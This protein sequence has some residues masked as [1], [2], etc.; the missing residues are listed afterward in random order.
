MIKYKK[1]KGVFHGIDIDP[2]FPVGKII[3]IAAEE[4]GMILHSC[5]N[6]SFC[7]FIF[8]GYN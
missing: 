1:C 7:V 3:K 4:K 6:E 5:G 2:R 8:V